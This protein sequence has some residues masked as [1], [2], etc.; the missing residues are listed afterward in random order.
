MYAS[1]SVCLFCLCVCEFLCLYV[2]VYYFVRVCAYLLCEFVVW[3]CVYVCMHV[4]VYECFRC[5]CF[6]VCLCVFVCVVCVCAWVDLNV[7]EFLCEYVEYEQM[8]VCVWECVCTHESVSAVAKKPRE[9]IR[10]SGAWFTGGCVLSSVSAGNLAMSSLMKWISS[11]HHIGPYLLPIHGSVCPNGITWSTAAMVTMLSG[12]HTCVSS[13]FLIGL[14]IPSF[15]SSHCL[16]LCLGD[17][18]LVILLK[19]FSFCF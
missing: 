3:L 13:Y 16:L 11:G 8:Y 1:S 15:L 17:F 18:P 9:V 7:C 12:A 5:L 14:Y 6:C 4:S 10:P 19:A 2:F